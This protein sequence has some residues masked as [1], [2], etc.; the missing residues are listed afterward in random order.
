MLAAHSVEC[1]WGS[2]SAPL[3][4]SH[5]PS[6]PRFQPT[7]TPKRPL[8][9]P[10]HPG[11]HP[12]RRVAALPAQHCHGSGG[13][14]QRCIVCNELD[15]C[16]QGVG[17]WV[18]WL[19]EGGR[20]YLV[21]TSTGCCFPSHVRFSPLPASSTVRPVPGLID[22]APGRP[23]A[24]RRPMSP[25]QDG[26]RRAACGAPLSTAAATSCARRVLDLHGR[27]PGQ[28][29]RVGS[30]MPAQLM[31]GNSA[32]LDSSSAV[33]GPWTAAVNTHSPGRIAP[34]RPLPSTAPAPPSALPPCRAGARCHTDP[35]LPCP[36]LAARPQGLMMFPQ[37]QG[38]VKPVLARWSI[39]FARALKAHLREDGDV[40]AGGCAGGRPGPGEAGSLLVARGARSVDA[41]NAQGPFTVR[42]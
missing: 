22:A 12:G 15:A 27:Q 8:P 11:R 10:T 7:P 25:M 21:A 42:L 31:A 4:R 5:K 34:T 24:L 9:T 38:A 23:N 20:V 41:G 33:A 29:R 13:S 30:C 1:V 2:G 19:K 39:A 40:G 6:F 26:T 18:C 36:S 28:G 35:L 16:L 17:T 3:C 14:L 37:D 32:P